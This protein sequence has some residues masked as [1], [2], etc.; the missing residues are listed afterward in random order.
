MTAQLVKLNEKYVYF[1]TTV[2]AAEEEAQ[3]FDDFEVYQY[4]DNELFLIGEKGSLMKRR[5]HFYDW[6]GC[7][8]PYNRLDSEKMV[9]WRLSVFSKLKVYEV[10]ME[11]L[12]A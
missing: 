11:A 3:Y 12:A 6:N 10:K 1:F 4:D 8:Y 9:E 7:L 2:E 5:P